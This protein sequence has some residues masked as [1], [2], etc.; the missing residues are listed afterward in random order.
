MVF[1]GRDRKGPQTKT[2]KRKL[3]GKRD[4]D[5]NLLLAFNAIWMA[6]G[7]AP[8]GEGKTH[9]KAL[10]VPSSSICLPAAETP[11]PTTLGTGRVSSRTPR[12]EKAAVRKAISASRRCVVD[13][14][15]VGRLLWNGVVGTDA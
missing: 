3:K 9:R 4:N 5:T 14:G 11:R 2:K 1:S 15:H 13:Q 10:L 6:L 7:A 8:S 12:H